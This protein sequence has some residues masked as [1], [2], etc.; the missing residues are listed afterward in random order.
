[1]RHSNGVVM[2]NRVLAL[3]QPLTSSIKDFSGRVLG[4]ASFAH[5]SLDLIDGTG[6]STPWESPSTRTRRLT[7]SKW[8]IRKT[9]AYSA[10]PRQRAEQSG[11]SNAVFG[12]PDFFSY[13]PNQFDSTTSHDPTAGSLAYPAAA[14]VDS[15]GD[16]FVAETGNSRVLVFDNPLDGG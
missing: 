3:S 9:A 16:L 7:A 4:Q 2:N 13:Y 5:N 12:E 14:V 10:T 11:S 1:M 8:S 6:Y 15:S